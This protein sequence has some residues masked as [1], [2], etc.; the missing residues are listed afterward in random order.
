VKG[1]ADRFEQDRTAIKDAAAKIIQ[2]QDNLTSNVEGR[3]KWLEL[4]RALDAALPKDDRERKDT[5]EHVMSRTELHIRSLDAQDYADVMGEYFTPVEEAYWK[6]KGG[7]P[8]ESADGGEASGE[9]GTDAPLETPVESVPVDVAADG[10]EAGASSTAG[11]VIQ[12][13]GFHYHNA[14]KRDQTARFVTQTL[15][16]NLEEGTVKLPD[17][18]GGA[19][20]DVPIKDIGISRP[21]LVIGKQLTPET[22]DPDAGLRPAG[23]VTYTADSPP[24]AIEPAAAGAEGAEPDKPR[25]FEVQKYEFVVQFVW[26]PTTR[27]QRVAIAKARADAAAAAKAAAE[28]AAAAEGADGGETTEPAE[29]AAEDV[30]ATQ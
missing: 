15:L 1:D 2:I 26:Q 18:P 9:V 6:S 22:I 8:G 4:T 3:L 29:P 20:I 16:K 7:R 10:A 14:D 25:W 5:A 13:T 19:L 27:S 17:G 28:E 11:R 23:S 21:W 30:T 24:P 12:L